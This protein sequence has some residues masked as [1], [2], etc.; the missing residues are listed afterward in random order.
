MKRYILPIYTLAAALCIGTA[1]ITSCSDPDDVNDLVLD[2]VLSPTGL[3]ARISQDVNIIVSW[4]EMS[5]ASSYEVEAYADTP[6][7]DQRTP[8]FS[9]NTELTEV[10]LTNLVGETDYYIRVRALDE[11]NEARSS[12]WIETMRTTNPEQNMNK[13]KSGDIQS[14]AVKVTWTAGIQVD[15]IVC[16]PST[17]NSTAETVTYTLTEEDIANGTATIEGLTPETS[18]RATLKLGEK[19]RGYA[20]F[21]TNLDLRD[22]VALAPTDNDWASQIENAPAGS[23]FALAPGI[24]ELTSSKLQINNDITIGAQNSG[25]LPIL[26]TCIN[27]NNGASLHLYQVVM[28]GTGT[29]GSQA[30]DYKSTGGFD[31]LTI[32]GCEIRNYTKGLIY[33]NVTAVI[34]TIKIDNSLIHD[35]T[36]DGGDFIDSRNGGWNNLNI[37][38]STIYDSAAKRDVLRGDN[39]SSKV[40][41]SMVTVINQCTFYNVGNGNATYRFFFLRFPGNTNT[42]TNNVIVN[43]NNK[44]GFANSSSVGVPTYSNNYYYNCKNLISQA[45]DNTESGLTCF[46]T[47]GTVLEDNP[48][49]NPDNGDFTIT[50]ELYQS[51]QFGDPRWY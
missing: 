1:T 50:N 12:K 7:Y 14:T 17:A 22:A 30:I 2:R 27:I 6:D 5:G 36:C 9:T 8:D 46:D 10:T 21:T 31:A 4:N 25:D 24:Y 34:N 40:N 49:A 37:T 44:R 47:E 32:D 28:D 19:T 11:N 35:I 15:V 38:N 13:V 20:T 23:K 42:F 43:F 45:E 41:A 26:N 18:Y 33:I 3:T 48:F 16:I 29:D 39:A 51:Y